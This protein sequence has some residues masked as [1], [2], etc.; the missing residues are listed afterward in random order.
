L[1]VFP[2]HACRLANGQFLGDAFEVS[3]TPSLSLLHLC[4]TRRR[5]APD[6]LLIAQNPTADLPFTE[7]EGA[8][9]AAR[10]HPHVTRLRREQVTK[11]RLLRE[12]PHCR[13]WHYSGHARFNPV[14][15]LESALILDNA[16]VSDPRQ[17]APESWLTVR[18]TFT[19]LNLRQTVLAILPDC[20]TARLLPD[21]TDDYVNLPTGFLYSGALCVISAHWSI[22][23]LSSAIVM[24]KYHELWDAGRGLAPAAALREA[25]RW[26]REEIRTKQQLERDILPA[27]LARVSD[28]AALAACQKAWN[29]H[30]K[31]L[32][33]QY[34]FASPMHWAPFVASGASFGG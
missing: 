33:E 6:T 15:P 22:N 17:P 31:R 2:L 7:L 19:A 13:V 30:S 4:A 25:A 28:P 34:P 29:E 12:A 20:E 21:A 8:S 32:P 27:L 1:H 9:A 26:L 24:A 14:A 16:V 18:D 3:Y 5:P 23:D 11:E 10:F